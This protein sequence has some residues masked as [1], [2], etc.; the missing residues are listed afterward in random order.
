M[1][2]HSGRP[3]LC[4]KYNVPELLAE[5]VS[6][7]GILLNAFIIVNRWTL[8]PDMI[9]YGGVE[10]AHK[11]WLLALGSVLPIGAYVALTMLSGRLDRF[12]YPVIVSPGNSAVQYRLA[13]DLLLSLKL[14]IV[15]ASNLALWYFTSPAVYSNVIPAVLLA[16]ALVTVI[17]TAAYYLWQ[18]RRHV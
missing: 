16:L 14:E 6:L 4:L 7:A 9:P 10:Q 11:L 12:I 18:M 2:K 17:V 8:L 13:R 1:Y 5:L 3:R 15:W